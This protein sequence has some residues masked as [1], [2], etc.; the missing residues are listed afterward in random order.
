MPFP[1]VA[2]AASLVASYAMSTMSGQTKEKLNNVLQPLGL[3]TGD[4][5]LS[6][7][8][9]AYATPVI[10]SDN[11]IGFWDEDAEFL[12]QA[13]IDEGTEQPQIKLRLKQ[14]DGI[15]KLNLEK[16]NAVGKDRIM[17]ERLPGED[18]IKTSE[19]L[20]KEDTEKAAIVKE[21]KYQESLGTYADISSQNL[22][23]DQLDAAQ[24]LINEQQRNPEEFLSRG[25]QSGLTGTQKI[26]QLKESLTRKAGEPLK[27]VPGDINTGSSGAPN[28]GK[29]SNV[30]VMLGYED[31][32][33]QQSVLTKKKKIF[34]GGRSGG[35]GA[36]AG[37]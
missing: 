11:R 33:A 37:V 35:F 12:V 22:P 2:V 27:I 3:T 30:D 21:Q 6:Y 10:L 26:T 9:D 20:M 14:L 28:T 8:E 31:P 23:G 13:Y 18:V 15:R 29:K 4:I 17:K 7:L 5:R 24:R 25:Q 1:L 34:G 36:G 32:L 19:R 16:L